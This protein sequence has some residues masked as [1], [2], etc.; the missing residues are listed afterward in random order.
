MAE[1]DSSTSQ[2]HP[3]T[4]DRQVILEKL[5]SKGFGI[6]FETIITLHRCQLSS[7]TTESEFTDNAES[8]NGSQTLPDCDQ[9]WQTMDYGIPA[10]TAE[11]GTLQLH[12]CD[13]T[14]GDTVS[15]FPLRVDSCYS[16]LDAHF[17]AFIDCTQAQEA[18]KV[19]CYGISTPDEAVAKKI[20]GAVN[21]IVPLANQQSLGFPPPKRGRFESGGESNPLGDNEWVVIERSDVLEAEDEEG[22]AIMEEGSD[23]NETDSAFLRLRPGM[24]RRR[25]SQEKPRPTISD[26]KEFRHISHVG[27][28]TSVSN[29]TKAMSV[30]IS[31]S[32][33]ISIC[34]SLDTQMSVET[35]TEETMSFVEVPKEDLP[36]YPAIVAPP[37]PPP[38]PPPEVKEL[39]P[40]VIGKVGRKIGTSKPQNPAISLEDILKRR[41]T[42]RPVGGHKVVPEP[43]PKPDRTKLFSDINTFDRKTLKHTERQ[44]NDN[45]DLDDPNCLQSILK[46]SLLKMREK[47]STNFSQIGNVNSEGDEEGFGEDYEGPL[48]VI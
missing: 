18:D 32:Q 41:G 5:C 21:R 3:Q 46:A 33:D 11:G 14:S 9:E 35:G 16:E 29:M 7:P 26:P 24:K 6:V 45:T 47:L 40:V 15:K 48:F 39:K 17:H 34:G 19:Y 10:I 38:P 20:L 23:D 1:Q 8:T 31:S 2:L 25:Q 42:L 27:Q 12:V 44:S 43:P 28:D 4:P 36:V 22:G 37:P 30:D 13:V